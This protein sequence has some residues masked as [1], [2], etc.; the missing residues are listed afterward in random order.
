MTLTAYSV[1]GRELSS[2]EH[3][4]WADLK[5]EKLTSGT[6]LILLGEPQE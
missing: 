6:D 3:N 2:C 1:N 5:N 4:A